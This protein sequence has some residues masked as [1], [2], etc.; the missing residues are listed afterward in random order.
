MPCLV[1]R[2]VLDILI[3]YNF[4]YA[5]G[6]TLL[7]NTMDSNSA[8]VDGWTYNSDTLDR[9]VFPPVWAQ[10]TGAHDAYDKGAHVYYNGKVWE[11]TILG[12]VWAPGVSG[13]KE[14]VGESTEAP[15]WVQPTGAHDSYAKDSVVAYAGKTWKSL[16]D[17]NVWEP[18]LYGWNVYSTL[19]PPAAVSH[20]EW[21]QPTG[22]HDAYA[23][24]FIV[25]HNGHTWKSTVSTNVW[26]P[27]VYGWV[28]I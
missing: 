21:V 24:D 28:M 10:P 3:A 17:A 16:V 12:N 22:A 14:V 19:P 2:D 4:V 27:G 9:D 23:I 26:E 5:P 20:P 8:V 1:K 11:S 18:G 25:T 15:A 7:V 13:W 6:Y